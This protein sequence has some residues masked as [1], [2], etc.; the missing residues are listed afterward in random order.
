MGLGDPPPADGIPKPVWETA[1]PRLAPMLHDGLARIEAG[2]LEVTEAGRRFV[3]H[4]AACF[5]ARLA[6]SQARHSRAV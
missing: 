6:A 4:V 1:E 3:R 5:D 2:R